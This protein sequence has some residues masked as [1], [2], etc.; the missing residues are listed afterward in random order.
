MEL[1]FTTTWEQYLT[2]DVVDEMVSVLFLGREVER[3]GEGEVFWRGRGKGKCSGEGG[4]RGS[5]LE[6]EGSVL[7]RD[8]GVLGREGG[9][10]VFWGGY[11]CLLVLYC[12]QYSYTHTP[13]HNP[14]IPHT[15]TQGTLA[16]HYRNRPNA[17]DFKSIWKDGCTLLTKLKVC[18]SL[19]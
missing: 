15:P 14:H 19:K 1:S 3:E 5:V 6:R 12:S 13:T 4:G 10:K 7:G 17:M 9:R 2:Q 11:S 8:G 16:A 18:L